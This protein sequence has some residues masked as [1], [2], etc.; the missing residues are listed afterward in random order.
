V[1]HYRANR[2]HLED[3]MPAQLKVV[4]AA[5]Q[6][7]RELAHSIFELNAGGGCTEALLLAEGY[8]RHELEIFGPAA[9]QLVDR[10]VIRKVDEPAEGF[11]WSEDDVASVF[12]DTCA[13]LIDIGD[14]IAALRRRGVPISAIHRA[15]PRLAVKMASA[16]AKM[17]AP[18]LDDLKAFV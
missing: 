17:T 7:V 9:R 5:D 16:I 3:A 8:S 14:A 6:R 1:P 12:D 11:S 4:T 15:W 18:S 13:G 10:R 2:F